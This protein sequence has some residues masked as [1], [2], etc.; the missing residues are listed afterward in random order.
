MEE[1]FS[2][3]YSFITGMF[4]VELVVKVG[5]MLMVLKT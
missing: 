5:Q 4:V 2:D 3:M 1:Q